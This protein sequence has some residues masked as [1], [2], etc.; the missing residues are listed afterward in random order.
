MEI[1]MF[2]QNKERYYRQS[3]FPLVNFLFAKGEKVAG[4]EQIDSTGKKEFCFVR[5]D[6]LEELED[7]Y[8]FGDRSD[9]DLAIQVHEYEQARRE[10]LER[11]RD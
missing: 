3:S 8:K 2:R 4:I 11:L 10:L 7:K 5:T 6:R 9:P 1:H